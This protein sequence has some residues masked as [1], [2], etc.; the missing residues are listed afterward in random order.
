MRTTL[1][2]L[3]SPLL[4]LALAAHTAAQNAM[5]EFGHSRARELAEL[6][7]L[8]T[9]HDVVVRDI[10]N[11][12]Q[13]RLPLPR[14]DR[15]VALDVRFDR[16]SA[17]DSDS[18]VLQVGYTTRPE[19]D[20][21]LAAPASVA[22]VVDCSGSMQERGKMDQVKR[23]L[24]EF[25][26]HLRDDDEVALIA[27]SNEARV[28]ASRR[29]RRDGRWLESAIDELQPTGSTNL[30]AGLM[31]GLRELREEDTGRRSQRVVL[32]TDGIANTGVT[33]PVQ[34]LADVE[35]YTRHAIDISTVGVG[36]N[37]DVPLLERLA[38]GTRGLFHFVADEQ[39][40]QKVF[41]EEVASLLM[42][43][44]RKP[45]L[46]ITLGRDLQVE[47]VFQE[48]WQR[49]GRCILVELPDLN[50]GVTGV[51]MVQCRIFGAS[52]P[53]L[54]ARAELAYEAA[55]TGRK[56]NERASAELRLR[57]DGRPEVDVEVRKNHAIAV[58][59]QGLRD[60]AEASERK[61]WADAD[62]SLRLAR[63]D[64]QRIFPGDDADLQRVREIAAGHLRTLQR[65]V[66][67]FRDH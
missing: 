30:H 36:Q 53:D 44:A 31:L 59:A 48:G 27:F 35:P 22:L 52:D 29:A 25:V 10:V 4:A 62:R 1:L 63:D 24:R 65:Y 60:M 51:V 8:P 46:E 42:P 61:R 39:D 9:S 18:V 16:S 6:G 17:G 43:V 47:R 19:G 14:A 11:Y 57:G 55:A 33:D 64:A 7:R 34:I 21:A 54:T 56:G 49:E 12:H 38:R 26:R 50:A 66:D 45:R 32:L 58:L 28:V 67:R 5:P 20:R 13:H 23:G 37:L 15:E 41:V 40:V 2:P 3:T